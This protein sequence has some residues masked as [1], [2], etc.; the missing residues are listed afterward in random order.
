[1]TGHKSNSNLKCLIRLKELFL[2]SFFPRNETK[3][4]IKG[5]KTVGLAV[6]DKGAMVYHFSNGNR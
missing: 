2:T 5:R 3:E 6:N 4:G 1:M